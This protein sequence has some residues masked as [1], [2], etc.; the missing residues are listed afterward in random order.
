MA[1]KKILAFFGAFNP[2]TV[3]HLDLA[4]LALDRAGFEGVMF[5]PSKSAYIRGEQHKDYA[6][7]DSERLEMLHAAAK[8]RPWMLVSDIELRSERQ[9]RTYDTLCRLR[10][11]GYA[12]SLLL[13]SDK[14]PELEKGWLHVNEIAKEFGIVCLCRGDDE[15]ER[16]IREDAFLLTLSPYIRVLKTPVNMHNVSSTAVRRQLAASNPTNETKLAV[17]KEVLRLAMRKMPIK[18]KKDET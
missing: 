14:L 1:S 10:E 11:L 17:S 18:E 16:M 9:P 12:P 4:K 15:G 3:A 13:G 5:V 7:S 6:Y 2:P 8:L